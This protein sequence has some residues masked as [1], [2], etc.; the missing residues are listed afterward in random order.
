[1]L[2]TKLVKGG[3]LKSA[4][5]NSRTRFLILGRWNGEKN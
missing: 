2:D 1:M 4:E 3:Q 5:N